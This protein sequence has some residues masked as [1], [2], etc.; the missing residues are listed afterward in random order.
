M[1]T[2]SGD[3]GSPLYSYNIV[4][5]NDGNGHFQ[6]TGQRLGIFGTGAVALGDLE[7]DG[8]LDIFDANSSSVGDGTNEPEERQPNII[9]LNDGQGI[10]S[11]SGQRLG[12]EESYSVALGDLDGDDDL[13]AFVGNR[14]A[15]TVWLNDGAGRFTDSGQRLG[16][17]DTRLVALGDM[18]G[19]GDMDV[20]S[21]GRGFAVIWLNQGEIQNGRA[22]FFKQSQRLSISIWYAFA[23]ADVDGDGDQDIF[24]GLLDKNTIVWR[25]DGKGRFREER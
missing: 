2:G 16:Q 13:D 9:W 18:D 11:D 23:M 14:G 22:G 12:R 20:L 17:D 15:D 24:A 10:F 4:W 5:L 19:D 1:T 25:N 6:D 3:P 21:A 8:D 7:G